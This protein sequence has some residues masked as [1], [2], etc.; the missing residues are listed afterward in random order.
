MHSRR[1]SVTLAGSHNDVA[2]VDFAQSGDERYNGIMP[3][4][5]LHSRRT[6]LFSGASKA[7]AGSF[8]EA[9]KWNSS[10]EELLA[11]GAGIVQCLCLSFFRL[12]QVSHRRI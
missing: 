10:C 7:A 1:A 9:E 4:W 6:F 2:A 11:A 3:L 8:G 5:T 12:Q